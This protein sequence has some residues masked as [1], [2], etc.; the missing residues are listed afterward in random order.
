MINTGFF[1]TEY[2]ILIVII[3]CLYI[4]FKRLELSGG[5]L[6]FVIGFR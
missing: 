3:Y 6:N 5:F 2:E 4:S 1:V